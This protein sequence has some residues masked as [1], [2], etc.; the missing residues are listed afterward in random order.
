MVP[1]T[2]Y[3]PMYSFIKINKNISLNNSI[4]FNL[5]YLIK[6]ILIF[7]VKRLN[8]CFRV[9]TIHFYKFPSNNFI[10]NWKK[11]TF[12]YYEFNSLHSIH[13][14]ASELYHPFL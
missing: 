9:F 7:I 2:H 10:V 1:L 11:E 4:L 5:M 14:Y 3:N 6:F 12:V 8:E 13:Y